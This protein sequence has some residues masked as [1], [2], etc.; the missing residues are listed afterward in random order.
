LDLAGNVLTWNAGA[1]RATGYRHDEISGRH[2]SVFY[3]PEDIEAGRPERALA[4]AATEGRVKDEGLRLRQDGTT[5]WASVAITA[6]RDRDG[7]LCGYGKIMR[8]LGATGSEHDHAH[9]DPG[10]EHLDLTS[11]F[12]TSNTVARDRR[13][14]QRDRTADAHDA[15]GDMR[16]RR[17]AER[18]LRADSRELL[19]DLPD[20]GSRTDRAA[21]LQDRMDGANDRRQA[22]Q[23]RAAASEDRESAARERLSASIDELTRAYRR[24][25]GIVELRREIARANRT[26]RPFVLAFIDLDDMKTTNDS[27]GHAA[28]DHRL[29][30]AAAVIH[31]H[32]R[33]YDL[34][35]RF[36]GDEFLGGLLDITLA[37]AATRFVSVND[38][39]TSTLQ[40][41][42]SVGF[43]ENQ[44]D[45][46]LE[47][48]IERADA[49][50]Y[51]ER[52]A[53]QGLARA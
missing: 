43:A 8:D 25:T 38:H 13:A 52:E 7:V 46:S 19:T 6:L 29:R 50:M 41:P 51:R 27:L 34:I 17:S 4:I 33:N 49:D 53:R 36:G 1:Q 30:Q 24:D 39:L 12:H 45:D 31:A 21:A 47:A 37:E 44:A 3:V 35:V 28:G 11:T 26:E 2:F 48:L 10:D 9:P 32:F 15:A 22:A 23:D 40:R 20:A 5:F 18:D 42:V 16:D 14:R